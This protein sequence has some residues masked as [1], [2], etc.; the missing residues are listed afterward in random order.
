MGQAQSGGVR[1][2][3]GDDPKKIGVALRTEVGGTR[4]ASTRIGAVKAKR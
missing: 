1:N 2:A 3:L 4:G